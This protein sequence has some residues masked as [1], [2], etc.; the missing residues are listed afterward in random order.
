PGRAGRAPADRARGSAPHSLAARRV[1][2]PRT[3]M[4]SRLD[5]ARARSEASRDPRP[6]RCSRRRGGTG[7]QIS[8]MPSTISPRACDQIGRQAANRRRRACRATAFAV[9]LGSGI[10][11]VTGLFSPDRS[12]LGPF[13]LLLMS[14]RARAS[15]IVE[16]PNADGDVCILLA[17]QRGYPS[18]CYHVDPSSTPKWLRAPLFASLQRRSGFMALRR[19]TSST[20]GLASWLTGSS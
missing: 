19:S 11:G 10:D 16:L 4:P 18:C 15:C 13:R 17:G 1:R 5:R 8:M 14:G 9:T 7:A 20:T 6:P 12:L 3:V 2:Q